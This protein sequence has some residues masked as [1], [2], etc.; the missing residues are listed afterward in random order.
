MPL[1]IDNVSKRFG[2]KWVLRDVDLEADRG[3]VIGVFG[4]KGCGKTTVLRI[5]AGL[6]SS[7]SGSIEMDGVAISELRSKGGVE[8]IPTIP[9]SGFW[10]KA[11]GNRTGDTVDITARQ[12]DLLK[13]ALTRDVE[14]LLLDDVFC[15]FDG[16]SKREMIADLRREIRSRN[17]I[18][19][20]AM[21]SF[22][23]IFAAC[24]TVA[25][26]ANGTVAQAGDPIQ[27]Y[28]GPANRAVAEIFGLNNLFAARRLTS[29]KAELPEFQTRNGD[30]RLFA[31]KTDRSALGSLNQDVTLAIRPEHI[32]ISFGASFP[33]DNLLKATITEVQCHGPTT[34]VHLDSDGLKLQALVLRLVGLKIGDECQNLGPPDRLTVLRS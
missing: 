21:N 9:V 30:H 23:D 3:F 28:E 15:F 27:V 14:L 8:F 24:D 17:K 32:S 20:I 29:S 18:A 10:H 22:E 5:I 26:V 34:I 33:E 19:L 1:R 2:T 6:E 4:P 7:N 11:L 13:N 31:R 12:A 16:R 25:I